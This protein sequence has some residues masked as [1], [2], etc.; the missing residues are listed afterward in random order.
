MDPDLSR[1]FELLDAVPAADDAETLYS[2]SRAGGDLRRRNL[3][4]YLGLVGTERPEM[5]LV[6]E[7]PGW[8]GATNTGISFMSVRELDA[9]P[10]LITQSPDGDGFESPVAPTAPWEAS[11]RVVWAALEGW[12]G[13]LPLFWPIFP[14][15]PFVPGQPLTNRTPRPAEIRDGTPVALELARTFGVRRIVAVG[16]KAQG[17]LAANGVEAEAVRHPAQGG[18]ALFTQQLRALG[19]L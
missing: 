10:G 6:G 7:A 12:R 11:S 2:T 4:R 3:V 8:R 14:H 17:A 1:F 19:G 9:R 18:A 15:H 13:P 5:I 16:R